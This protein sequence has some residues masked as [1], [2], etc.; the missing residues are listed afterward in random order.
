[1]GFSEVSPCFAADN[2]IPTMNL[3][4]NTS[5]RPNLQDLHRLKFTR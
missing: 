1:V 5:C 4:G 2:H 3:Q